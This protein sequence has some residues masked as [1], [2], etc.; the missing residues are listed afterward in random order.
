MH[1]RTH[2]KSSTITWRFSRL[3][4]LDIWFADVGIVVGSWI[5]R[6]ISEF[7]ALVVGPSEVEE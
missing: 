7:D 6:E 1:T 5:L 2:K 3:G 4:T